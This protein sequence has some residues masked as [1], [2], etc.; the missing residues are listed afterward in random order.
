MD[1]H[2]SVRINASPQEV[3]AVFTD[4]ARWQEWLGVPVAEAD[5]R[6]GGSLR[7]A[8]N[9]GVEGGTV[10]L[11]DYAEGRSATLADYWADDIYTLRPEG[12]GC[13]LE[14]RVRPKNGADFSADGYP[15]ECRR[16]QGYLN[17]FRDLVERTY[18]R[19]VPAPSRLPEGMTVNAAE[20]V[21]AAVPASGSA[22]AAAAPAAPAAPAPTRKKRWV[23]L[24]IVLAVLIAAG[25]LAWVYLPPML[26]E[27]RLVAQYNQG[28]DYLTAGDYDRAYEVF[29][30]LG[31]YDDAP[32]LALYAEKG[33]AYT[34]A[35][36]DMERG[37]YEE[38]RDAFLS[39]RGFKDSEALA[40]ECGRAIAYREARLLYASGDYAAALAA[41]QALGDYEDA[42]VLAAE[43]AG[44]LDRQAIYDAVDRGEYAL[45]LELL[46]TEAG[47]QLSGREELVVECTN[48][49]A[50][51]EAE[52]AYNDGLYYTA[53]GLFNDLGAYR[54]APARAQSCIR[55][56]PFTGETYRNTAYSGTSVLLKIQPPTDDGSCTYFKIYAV[57]G[58]NELLVS[59]AFINAGGNTTVRLPAGSY[60]FKAAYGYG[61]WYGEK[62]MFGPQGTYQRLKSSDTSE[63]FQLDR[64]GSYV[65]TLRAATD[66]NVGTRSESRDDF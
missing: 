19:A 34:E 47:Q 24:V 59:S 60:I 21:S 1:I 8:P 64:N 52:D 9:N 49:L 16:Q 23:P 62:E 2:V 42:K 38:A 25:A 26:R 46:D 66:G 13:V 33:V 31:D 50:Y 18:P 63:I 61:D 40:A 53:Y 14:K 45:A 7:Y 48:G 17:A 65:L 58:S 35:V 27:Q 29:R 10:P 28:A 39:L 12:D 44:Y 56:R 15:R 6:P 4:T 51:Q 30:E 20:M 57:S 3:W 55:S 41:L 5:W 22:A 32:V 37:S 43:C 11:S 54:D 36:R